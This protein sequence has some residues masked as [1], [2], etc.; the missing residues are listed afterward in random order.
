MDVFEL[1][2][3]LVDRYRRYATSFLGISDERVNGFVRE[4]L[5]EQRLWPAPQIGLNPAF[6]PGGTIDELADDGLLH[7][8]CREIFR[9]GKSPPDPPELKCGWV[10][11]PD[12]LLPGRG[13]V[14]GV[15]RER[16][17]DQLLLVGLVAHPFSRS[18]DVAWRCAPFMM[19]SR[20]GPRGLTT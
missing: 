16:D 15:E 5:D 9:I 17:L 10:P 1:R 6:E 7:E 8:R 20:I 2:D 19:V 4:A 13:L 18:F 12:G 14:D 3:R 11:V